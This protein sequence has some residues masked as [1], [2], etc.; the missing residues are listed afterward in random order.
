MK[1]KGYR[2]RALR[3][4]QH[5]TIEQLADQLKV[6]A[7]TIGMYERGERTPAM[8]TLLRIAQLFDVSLEFF[9]NDAD[10]GNNSDMLDVN[11]ESLLISKDV[12][13]RAAGRCELCCSM[14]PF[15]TSDGLPYLELYTLDESSPSLQKTTALCPNC[16]KKLQVLGLPGDK[17]YLK[18]K[19]AK[20]IGDVGG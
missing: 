10:S 4:S 12:M 6:S 7:S 14:A 1:I 8:R 19:I 20:T 11:V 2:I 9:W 17:M 5:L 13:E 18:N 15:I 3:K 16:K